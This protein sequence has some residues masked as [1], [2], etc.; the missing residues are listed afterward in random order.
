VGQTPNHRPVCGT[1]EVLVG[2]AVRKLFSG[3]SRYLRKAVAAVDLQGKVALVTGGAVRVGKA[4][5]LALAQAGADVAF[6]YHSS[7]EEAQ[8]TKQELEA[9]GHRVYAQKAD[10]GNVSDCRALVERTVATLGRL[11]VLVNSASLWKRTKFADLTEADWDLVTDILL[12]GTVFTS[13][14][15]APYLAAH[16]DGA[17]V[18][19]TD[20]SAYIPFPNHVA[21]SAG[22]AGVLNLTRSLA[23][24]LAPRVRVNAIAPGPVLPPPVYGT[25]QIQATADRTLL[26]RWGTAEDVAE[27]VVFLVRANF[28]TGTVIEV[29][30]GEHLACRH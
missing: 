23:I 20:L 3:I 17:I 7:A 22:K 8:Q 6:S 12:K 2:C 5:A 18:N 25:R 19:I 26:K 13:H 27:A 4:I 11:D 30:G 29:D 1:R 14:A 10:A 16:G 24:E 15:A 21:H 9:F 28:V